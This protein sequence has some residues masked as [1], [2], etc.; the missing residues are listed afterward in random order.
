MK[1]IRI[2]MLASILPLLA[3]AEGED[4]FG[5]WAEIGIEKSLGSAKKWS[6]GAE[7]EMRA[8]EK[9]RWSIGANLGYKP[10]KYLKLGAAYNFLYRY[11]PE[12]R[13]EHYSEDIVSE[14]YWNGFNV[15]EDYWSPRHRL[16]VE[17]TGTVKLWKWLRIS[18]RERYQYTRRMQS[19]AEDVKYRYS[20]IYNGSGDFIGYE[21]KD[22]YPET[23]IDTIDIEDNHILR[24]RLK[25][26]VDK[27]GLDLSPFVY[28][29]F[30]N[31]L[32]SGKNFNL[33]KIR[34]AIGSEYKINKRNEISLAYVL[35]ANIH[36][37]EAPYPRLHERIHALQ[38]G[39]NFKF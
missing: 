7:T 29:E 25:L 34:S 18:L 6:I 28:V 16:S 33:E 2:L 12:N 26:S 14:E 23:E 11:K 5:G 4:H 3:N 37:E 21:L 9:N 10:I 15:R 39:Y 31:S 1:R 19:E 17:A 13:R 32:N 38:M 30:H 36:D 20:K 24:S 35:T 8:Q 22:E 27:K